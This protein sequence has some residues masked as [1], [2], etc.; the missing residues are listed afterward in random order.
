[1]VFHWSLSDSK[2]LQVY[3][4]LLSILATLTNTLIRR[5]LILL[6]ISCSSIFFPAFWD[7]SKCCNGNWY[8]YH[9][10]FQFFQ[11]FANRTLLSILANL[12]NTL[13]RRFLIRLLI[14]SSSIFFSSFWDHSKCCNSNWYH[15]HLIFQFFQFFAN[16]TLLS[17]LANLTNTLIRRFLIRLLI[18]SSSIFFSSF[19]DHSKCCNS[20]W[21]HHHLIFQFFQFFANRTLL[22]IL[23]NLTNTLIRR[24]LIRLLISSSSIFSQLFGTIPSAATA[25]GITIT[26]YFSFFNSLPT[27]LFLVF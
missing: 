16:R 7:H 23:A 26:S 2:S 21:Y 1:M 6:P 22:G 15:H 14:S 3:R 20:N 5:V 8:H 24:V 10:I 4:T 17:I 25:I 12:T 9:L 27:G 11:F 13:I 18:S 19:W